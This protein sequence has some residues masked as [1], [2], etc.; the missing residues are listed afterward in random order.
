[1]KFIERLFEH[2]KEQDTNIIKDCWIDE[3]LTKKGYVNKFKD[4]W[5]NDSGDYFSRRT[6]TNTLNKLGFKQDRTLKIWVKDNEEGKQILGGVYVGEINKFGTKRYYTYPSEYI[7]KPFTRL[8]NIKFNTHLYNE[9]K[10]IAEE[11]GIELGLYLQYELLKVLEKQRPKKTEI[12]KIKDD[13]EKDGFFKEE[14]DYIEQVY[15]ENKD[16]CSLNIQSYLESFYIE[17]F[18]GFGYKEE[19]IEKLR[20]KKRFVGGLLGIYYHI[21]KKENIKELK[22]LDKYLKLL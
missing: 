20:N 12:E 11:K 9:L 3:M 21:A 8:T 6:L 17:Y 13:L 7:D 18:R 10:D 15:K 4:T 5:G 2:M 16:F 1:M 14:I 19:Q 22:E